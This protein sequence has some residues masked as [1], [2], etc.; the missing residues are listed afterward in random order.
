MLFLEPPKPLA[1]VVLKTFAAFRFTRLTFENETSRITSAT[2]LTLP[3]VV[4]VMLG[5]MREQHVTMTVAAI[6]VAGSCLAFTIRYG[7]SGLFYDG[8]RR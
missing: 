6:Q 3:N 2:N 7:L 4:L 8:D 1:V 5:P